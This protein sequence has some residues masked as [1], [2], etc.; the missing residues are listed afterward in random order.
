MSN[1]SN[2]YA[3]KVFAE[4][5]VAMW[6][7]DED[8]D[9][10]SFISESQRDLSGWAVS[11]G[12]LVP[13]IGAPN[14]PFSSS[15]LSYALGIPSALFN[16]VELVSPEITSTLLLNQSLETFSIGTYIYA[17]NPYVTGYEIGYQYV[18]SSTG[19]DK[20]VLR[21]FNSTVNS[22][23]LFISETFRIPTFATGIKIVIKARY[24]ADI[25]DP[26]PGYGF[27]II[28]ISLG[29]WS[30]EFSAES[31]GID[32][33]LIQ[34]I[35]EIE[36]GMSG[37]E[38]YS[39]A[40]EEDPAYYIANLNTLYAKNT[41]VPMVFGSSNTTK[42]AHNPEGPSLI[43]SGKGFLNQAGRFQEY[44]LETW[45][46]VQSTGTDLRRIIGPIDS[47]DGIYV[48][49]PFITL[50]I[51]SSFQSHFVGDWF[52]PMLLTLRLGIDYATV[53]INGQEVLSISFS[54]AE[55]D[56][57]DSDRDWIGFYA[58]DDIN[59]FEVD[60]VSIY[61]Y[62][63][64]AVL[65]K[66]RFAFGQAVESPEGVNRSYGGVTALIDYK[67]ADYTNN[68]NYPNI[69]KWSQGI[70]ENLDTSE[71]YLSP[72]RY[73]D[74][75]VILK[76]TTLD[77]FM[78]SQNVG[79]NGANSYLKFD[80]DG[81]IIVNNFNLRFQSVKGIYGIFEIQEYSDEEKILIK[82]ENQ[83]TGSSFKI[84]LQ[85]EY[86]LY[87]FTFWGEERTLYY[88]S[89]VS[90]NAK[91]FAGIDI[92]DLVDFFGED[93]SSFF[94]NTN[95]L[96]IYVANDKA[97]SAQ[98][99]G[100]IHRFGICTA[101]NISKIRSYFDNLSIEAVDLTAEPGDIYFGSFDPNNPL[102]TEFFQFFLDGGLVD[103]FEI[104]ELL[105]H[106]A[107]YTVVAKT[108][109]SK[110]YLDIETESYW[111]DYI[112]LTYFAQYVKDIFGQDVYD[113]DFIQLN[114]D[115]PAIQKFVGNFYD[116]SSEIVKTY[117][118]FQY[119]SSGANKPFGSF[120][121]TRLMPKNGVVEPEDDWLTTKYEVVDG[122]IIY[123]PKGVSLSEIA[124]VTHIEM[125]AD[126]IKTHPLSVKKLEY[127][128]QAFN[129]TTSNPVGTKFGVPIFPYTQYAAVFDYKARNPFSIYKGS[130]PHLYLSRNSGISRVGDTD[131]LTPRGLSIPININS[132]PTYR[133]VAMQMF[134]LYNKDAFSSIAVQL[135]EVQGT[136][137][138]L[139]FY[140]KANDKTGQRGRLYAVNA[141]TGASEDGIAFYI[142]GKLVREPVISLNEW[143]SIGI[144]FATTMIFDEYPGAIRLT[145][146][147]LFNNVAHYESSG[148][149]EVERQ[150]KRSWSR[151]NSENDSWL[152]V[153]IA[154]AS[155]NFLWNDLLVVSSVSFFGV[156]PKDIYRAY[157][158]TNK[159]IADGAAPLVI[160]NAEY[161]AFLDIDWFSSVA[162]PV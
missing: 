129:D 51:G 134:M 162:T 52:R 18:D 103:T 2:L 10:I 88:K 136:E 21:F 50:S 132:A 44:T 89:G 83:A 92:D 135:F 152:Q 115:Y 114:L 16:D 108:N 28:V 139:R 4:H 104:D 82:I 124:I 155:G 140:V 48:N 106:I 43:I 62:L 105:S 143:T 85:S 154:A 65:S 56:L 61:S 53:L 153:L 66:R 13:A 158:G 102:S 79:V 91:F 47:E 90:E 117:V 68:Y 145:D 22:Q 84:S 97:F 14:P 156:N 1:S 81:Y 128:S 34:D 94:G 113:L 64:P 25:L 96:S 101:R 69:G 99:D 24:T 75:T 148:L 26:L 141:N 39:Y 5:P 37:I 15:S 58:Y 157:V 74:P 20:Q 122:A 35:S 159:I 121:S 8:I 111:E 70:V 73:K 130:T 151:V 17:N 116:T 6:S 27:Y 149:Q 72:P 3:E 131:P 12:M 107:S 23:W 54:T 150:S 109:F 110:T 49:G 138:R 95:Q 40:K 55:L 46:R 60:V 57:P 93:I 76:D 142:N 127:A 59:S 119:L 9:Y 80:N 87:R 147:V 133:V 71:G 161:R 33:S 120:A 11:G 31:L 38:S 123:P 45:L 42:L 78:Q 125:L 137:K 77:Q 36:S 19:L 29:Q 98:F 146:S 100:R 112:P 144:S 126:G 32:Q 160:G 41:S 118:S 67:F 30:E 7:L 86:I 63:V